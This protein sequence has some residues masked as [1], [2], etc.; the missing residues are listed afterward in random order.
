M[1]GGNPAAAEMLLPLV[2]SERHRLAQGYMRR[3]R[4]GYTLQPALINEACLRLI[5]PQC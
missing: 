2:Y 3:E 5:W 4:P 1:H